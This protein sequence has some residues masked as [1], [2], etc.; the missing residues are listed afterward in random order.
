MV[1]PGHN[2]S[3]L[4]SGGIM[5][6]RISSGVILRTVDMRMTEF[7]FTETVVFGPPDNVSASNT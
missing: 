2:A 5:Y 4:C 7:R 3:T 1:V 6:A